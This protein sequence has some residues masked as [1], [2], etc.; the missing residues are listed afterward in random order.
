MKN[1]FDTEN[2]ILYCEN[3]ILKAKILGDIDHHCAKIIREKIDSSIFEYKPRLVI[4]DL[5]QVEFMD[6]SG[7]GLILGRYN[8]ASE[9][10]AEFKI[11]SPSSSVKRILALAGIERIIKIEGETRR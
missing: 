2:P 10:S 1:L 4:L 3:G 6:S 5:S 9:I 8:T 11:Y 7:L